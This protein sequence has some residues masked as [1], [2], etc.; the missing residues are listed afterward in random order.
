VSARLCFVLACQVAGCSSLAHPVDAPTTGPRGRDQHPSI[1]APAPS[2]SAAATASVA[3]IASVAEAP[4]SSTP[5]TSGADFAPLVS[6]K[7]IPCQDAP[8][9]LS[10]PK[11]SSSLRCTD[12]FHHCEGEIPVTIENCTGVELTVESLYLG[13]DDVVGERAFGGFASKPWPP[14]PAG[15]RVTRNVA[16]KWGARYEAHLEA[17]STKAT[18]R[19]WSREG[20]LVNPAYL[21]AEAA[22]KACH[23]NWGPQGI[24]QREGCTCRARDGGKPCYDADDC[25]GECQYDHIQKLGNGLGRNVGKCTTL[26]SDFG[27]ITYIPQG[28][29]K[30][31]PRPLAE[32]GPSARVCRD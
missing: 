15:M 19:L 5:R 22:C 30:K 27:C 23:G 17:K 16:V 31:S 3:P 13:A 6:E 29:S 1:V 21:A 7:P 24:L 18:Y 9:G 28:E 26:V 8:I 11:Q 10:I 4:S 32:L 25:E 20:T 12:G 2:P 14:V